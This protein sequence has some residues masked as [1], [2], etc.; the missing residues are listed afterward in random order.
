MDRAA[1]ELLLSSL[2]L[3]PTPERDAAL[4]KSAQAATNWE[5]LLPALEG[6]GVLLIFRRNIERVGVE[7]PPTVAPILAGRVNRLADGA[8]HA[9]LTLRRLL[10]AAAIERIELTLVGD[11]AFAFDTYPERTLRP[12]GVLELLVRA[13]DQSA[14]L[15]AA[16]QSGLLPPES[17]LPA[18]WHRAT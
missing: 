1:A 6:H 18:A 5:G 14:A 11:S 16:E 7:L 3:E 10:G 15:R 12:P 17:A 9:W 8:Q 2:F 13:R 4:T